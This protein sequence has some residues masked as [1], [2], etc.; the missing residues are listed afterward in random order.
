MPTFK[1]KLMDPE[2]TLDENSHRFESNHHIE[3]AMTLLEVA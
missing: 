1:A 3:Y 2:Y